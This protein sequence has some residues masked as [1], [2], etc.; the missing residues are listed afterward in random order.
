MPLQFATAILT[1]L[2]CDKYDKFLTVLHLPTFDVLLDKN[3]C[4]FVIQVSPLTLITLIKTPLMWDQQ[5]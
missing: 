3:L 2:V 1:M 5:D 4:D